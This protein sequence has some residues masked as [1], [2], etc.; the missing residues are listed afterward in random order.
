MGLTARADGLLSRVTTHHQEPEERGR[1]QH[2]KDQST[3]QTPRR[4]HKSVGRLR[5]L[6]RDSRAKHAVGGDTIDVG[7][8]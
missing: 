7:V 5:S 8:C 4:F 6:D 1:R 2:S 3:D